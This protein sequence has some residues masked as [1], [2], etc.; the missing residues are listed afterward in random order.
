M[1]ED[2]LVTWK[3]LVLV[4]WVVIQRLQKQQH[5]SAVEH[6]SA[7]IQWCLLC[8]AWGRAGQTEIF[9]QRCPGR[10]CKWDSHQRKWQREAETS[11]KS[12]NVNP[13]KGSWPSQGETWYGG[14]KTAQTVEVQRPPRLWRC[15]DRPDCSLPRQPCFDPCVLFNV[16]FLTASNL[17]V[18]KTVFLRNYKVCQLVCRW[19]TLYSSSRKLP[20]MCHTVNSH[21]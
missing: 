19:T 18:W 20:Y 17:F 21:K 3:L 12:L 1:H 8:K 15:K 13:G 4:S 14:A 9:S 10:K 5:Y 2:V 7:H 16:I 6:I 11:G